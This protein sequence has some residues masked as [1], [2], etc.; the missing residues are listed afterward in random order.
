MKRT[1]IKIAF[2]FLSI[3]ALQ[4]QEVVESAVRQYA[5]S[6]QTGHYYDL[7]FS[8]FDDLMNGASGEDMRGLN[9][10][11]SKFDVG[12]AGKFHYYYSPLLS[13]ELGYDRASVT[14]ANNVEWHISQNE[15]YTVGMKMNLKKLSQVND[16]ATIPFMKLGYGI[17]NYDAQR[18]FVS[19]GI[20]FSTTSGAT[21]VSDIGF[22]IQH[23]ISDAVS[24][25]IQSSW[26]I[27]NTD[28]WDGYD[29]SSGKD[30]LLVTTVGAEYAF[31]KGRHI[32]RLPSYRDV[33][34]NRL[35]L[36]LE[37]LK[38][39]DES[40]MQMIQLNTKENAQLKAD[41]E[42]MKEGLDK[43]A[44]AQE[45]LTSQLNGPMNGFGTYR[46][47]YRF[48]NAVIEK[49]FQ[50]ELQKRVFALE[51]EDYRIELQAFSDAKGTK[52]ANAFI[53]Q[54]RINKAKDL[55][56]SWGI[57]DEK[58]IVKKWSGEYTGTDDMDRRLEVTIKTN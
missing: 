46:I 3:G 53:R 12:F 8:S 10:L 17:L 14:G 16:Y 33:R 22:G 51:G 31:R 13:F 34:V 48:N 58:I 29:Y 38:S 57:S 30:H 24:V 44:E 20:M 37:T 56:N 47:Y 32:N 18:S 25:N 19:D 45:G 28:A 27:V 49:A 54:K 42:L 39:N 11:N 35:M 4:A 21:T 36:E 6:F 50:I 9:G 40:I 55:L 41:M 52:V 43:L 1:I 2:G 23:H 5:F 26:R 7:K 15:A